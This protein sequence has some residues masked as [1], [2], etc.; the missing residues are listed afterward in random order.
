MEKRNRETRTVE[1][2]TQKDTGF[3]KCRVR[4]KKMLNNACK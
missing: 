1:G 2:E 3:I 4:N